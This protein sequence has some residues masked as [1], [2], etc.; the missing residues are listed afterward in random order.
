MAES[1]TCI[2]ESQKANGWANHNYENS[3]PQKVILIQVM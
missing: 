1:L 3:A 2:E